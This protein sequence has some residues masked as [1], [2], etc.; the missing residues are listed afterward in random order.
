MTSMAYNAPAGEFRRS[1]IR[2]LCFLVLLE[3]I[4]V[5]TGVAITVQASR[6][7]TAPADAALVMLNNDASDH[8]RLDHAVQLWS[9]GNV[10]RIVLAGKDVDPSST[11]LEQHGVPLPM[12]IKAQAQTE[13][14]QI[15]D[16]RWALAEAR[17]GSVA[18]IAEPSQMLRV[19]KIARDAGLETRSLPIGSGTQLSMGELA[20]EIGRYFRYVLAGQ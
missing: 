13:A 17:L 12:I 6:R 16:T 11:Y 15:A 19:L 5:G 20:L 4:A 10:S 1:L 18:V 8:L 14:V 7:D 2:I 9:A 3:M